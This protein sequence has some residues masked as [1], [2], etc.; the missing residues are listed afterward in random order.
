[1][2][3][4]FWVVFPTLMV[5]ATPI[6][7]DETLEEIVVTADFVE[8]N[9]LEIPTSVSVIDAELMAKRQA[10]HLWEVVGLAPNVSYAS[11]ASR[12]RFFQIRGIGERSQ[13][14]DPIN[15]GVGLLIDGIDMSGVGNAA[16][17]FDIQQVEI[18]RGPQG[19]R[20]GSNALGGLINLQSNAPT[21]EFEGSVS[22]TLG[23]LAENEGTLDIWDLGL[24]LSGPLTEHWL[25][26]IAVQHHSSDG[27][28]DNVFLGRD[29]TSSIDQTTVRSRLR[30]LASDQTQVDFGVLFVNAD[31][32]Y[33]AFTLD[34]TR[35][36]FSDEPGR[37][38]QRTLAFNTTINHALSDQSRIV[39]LISHAASSIVYSFDE[40]WVAPGICDGTGDPCDA[41]FWGFSWEYSGFDEYARDRDTTAAE[42]RLQHESPNQEQ[43]WAIGLYTRV[44]DVDLAR[45]E[46]F[47]GFFQSGYQTQHV[48]VFGQYDREL[49]EQLSL[50]VG[51]RLENFDAE[52]GDSLG[53]AFEPDDFSWGGHLALENSHLT[54]ICWCTAV[55]PGALRPVAQTP[56][57]PLC[58]LSCRQ[59]YWTT[60]P[61]L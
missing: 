5:W 28:V 60:K 35:D 40:D 49:S 11:G 34:N 31:N 9:L 37:D 12:G 8:Q 38:L 53:V 14:I 56:R 20:F 16:G 15:P 29:D 48:A 54:T 57:V 21:S 44:Q 1:M 45:T 2:K 51:G 42:I 47:N 13:F 33:D 27:D 6:L 61:N 46:T 39:A 32:G 10:E 50:S 24:V 55:S 43:V 52:Y 7:A 4:C 3:T 19:S 18:L 41:A 26:R 58:Y 22:G 25:G 17:L 23:S 30:W 36:T 59:P